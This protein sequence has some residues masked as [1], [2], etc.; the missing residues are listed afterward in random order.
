M[1]TT[2]KLKEL[3]GELQKKL[4][5][6]IPEKWDKIY[7]Y[8][9][10]IEGINHLETGEMFFYY[11]PK[12]LLRKNPVN[13]YEVP[14]KFNIDEREYF[15]LADELY[16]TIKKMRNTFARINDK[17][18]SNIT[19]SIENYKFKIEFDYEDLKTSPYSSYDRHILWRYQYLKTDLNTYQKKERNIILDYLN[20]KP[21]MK[22]EK[23]DCYIEGI[24]DVKG[25]NSIGYDRPKESY[26]KEETVILESQ[27]TKQNK[28]K[29]TQKNQILNFYNK[30]NID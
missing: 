13:V 1:T 21:F 14:N 5:Y 2:P 22:Q 24:Y 26:Q 3:Y 9:S 25:H 16:G 6:M 4:F 18:W 28:E 15:C 8:A 12:G 27:V 17:K 20:N 30:N 23:K 10:V 29:V 11:F 19:I 7:L